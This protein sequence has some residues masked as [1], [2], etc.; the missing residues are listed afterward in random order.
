MDV[1][2]LSD[3]DLQ[4]LAKGDYKRI[5]D[6]GLRNIAGLPEPKPERTY[7][8][9]LLKDPAASLLSGLGSLTQFPGQL[10]G[11]VTGD[12]DTASVRAGKRLQ[13]TAEE[14]K[15][16]GLKGMEA[17]RAR[18]VQEAAER[19]GQ[20]GAFGTALGETL[21]SPSLLSGFLLEQAPQLLVPYGGAKIAQGASLA[22]SAAAGL[23]ALAAAE[24][25]GRTGVQAALGTAAVQQG[26][27]VGAGAYERIY[28]ELAKTMSP[29]EAAAETIN[30]ARAAGASGAII[31]LL[32]QKLPG[33]RALEEAFAGVP[34][35]A[36][37]A[38]RRRGAET[39]SDV[40]TPASRLGLVARGAAGEGASEVAE[41]VGGRFTQN[42][43][44]R[45]VKPEQALTE[46]LGETAAMALIGGAGMG[47][48]SGLLRRRETAEQPPAQPPAPEAPPPAAE[49]PQQ[50]PSGPDPEAVQRYVASLPEDQQRDLYEQLKRK[51][52][53]TPDQKVV[54][55]D[56]KEVT[57]P[58]IPAEL[59]TPQ[60][61]AAYQLLKAK[62][63]AEEKV[64]EAKP[65]PVD[66]TVTPPTDET[67]PTPS[68]QEEQE[69]TYIK[70]TPVSEN[71]EVRMW[72][73]KSGNFGVGV[74]DKDAGQFAPNIKFWPNREQA[75]EYFDDIVSKSA[76]PAEPSTS[77]TL[78]FKEYRPKEQ[79]D[80]D[81]KKWTI[82]TVSH[83]G[84]SL[85]AT[86]TP[87]FRREQ[88]I[89][90]PAKPSVSVEEKVKSLTDEQ[91]EALTDDALIFG[92]DEET[93]AAKAE[94]ARRRAERPTEE[95]PAGTTPPVTP[96]T[97]AATEDDLNKM[98]EELIEE[99][100]KAQ[101]GAAPAGAPAQAPA[102]APTPPAE[103]PVAGPAPKPEG[104]ATLPPSTTATQDIAAAAAKTAKAF[105]KAIDG[106][107]EL[108][109][110]GKKGRLGSGLSFDEETYAK[111]KPLFR[112]AIA[113]LAGA[114][115]DIRSA[116]RK[117]IQV[118][119]EKFGLD[120]AKRMQP[121]VVRFIQDEVQG[122]A[123]PVS[124]RKKLAEAFDGDFQNGVKFS[125]INAA[126]SRASE[127]LGRPV[128]P[129]TPDA[130]LVDE[131]VELAGVMYARRVVRQDRPINEIYQELIT[132]Q[133]DAMPRLAVR[134]TTSIVNQA[135]STPLPIA[136]VASQLA[137][138]N[139][140]TT[141]LEPTAGN[142][143]LLMAADP[144]KAIVNEI[145]AGR[146]N[147]LE[148]QGFAAT[149]ENA[150]TMQ[151]D[152]K[153]VDVVIANPPF[154]QTG[155]EYN[156]AGLKTGQIDHAIAL[157]ALQ[158]MKDDGRAVLIVGGPDRVDEDS[159]RKAYRAL[160]KRQFYHNLYN[161]Y[162]VKDHFTIGGDLYAKQGTTFPIDVI[163]IEGRG[164]GTRRQ[165]PAAALP[166]MIT[167]WDQLQGVL[168]G[169]NVD[170]G[171][172]R[173]DEAAT[174]GGTGGGGT[175]ARPGPVPPTT[176]EQGAEP[177][178]S[179]GSERVEPSGGTAEPRGVSGRPTGPGGGERPTGEDESRG[180]KRPR[181]VPGAGETTEEV[182]EEQPGSGGGV[183]RDD[184]TPMDRAAGTGKTRATV[185]EEQAEKLQVPY[186]NVSRSFPVNTLVATNHLT[187]IS[188]A[189]A[190]L[191]Q[192]VGNIDDYV[193]NKLQYITEDS[194][195][196]EKAI[197]SFIDNKIE[198]ADQRQL[199][200]YANNSE[201]VQHPRLYP[202][203]VVKHEN[204]SGVVI[205]RERQG[206]RI[207]EGAVAVLIDGKRIEIFPSKTS[208]IIQHVGPVAPRIQK[209]T[210][211]VE[212]YV[213]NSAA[214]YE[215]QKIFSAEQV[216]ALALAI[217]N[218]EAGRGFIIGDQT[219]IG[220]GRV[221]AA[222]IRY[223]MLNG[224][225]PV[226]LT[227]M[228]DLYGDMMRDLTDIGMPNVRPLM[229][230]NG[231]EVPLNAAA[232]RWFGEKQDIQIQ[233]EEIQQQIGRAHV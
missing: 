102:G 14:L 29:D 63:E 223:A 19:S 190:R 219:G 169:S 10:Y 53:G 160:S 117:I 201:L 167:T 144:N 145:E 139:D 28:E 103:V 155:G 23:P 129:G 97:G 46:G 16:A 113:N 191:E 137:G 226:F 122:Q 98:F 62:F 210:E 83:T 143:A 54:G 87:P 142:G 45:D 82:E 136:Y 153:S 217:Y 186:I 224:K 227:Q 126:R 120:I 73:A 72:Q 130:K 182:T 57:I 195:D 134:D 43:A 95:T 220:K 205:G 200:E 176:G 204:K 78:P 59:F 196:R 100:Q 91:L 218:I 135:Y 189:F 35:G 208:Q 198:I 8:E 32:A 56:G 116:M 125:N 215:L 123:G 165:Q 22:R 170:M 9:A 96:P 109:G 156:V 187:P 26:A 84:K 55:P 211:S 231:A 48:I 173:G 154:G 13:E 81:G 158:A 149:Q 180:A 80:F 213:F 128:E 216:E 159:R 178:E 212:Q 18:K 225:K 11:L 40:T 106:L 146:V 151:F 101:P 77:F 112:E 17:E 184:T 12:M 148:A 89:I 50:P 24:K 7:A 127:I 15:S 140:N 202:G 232:L 75:Q 5:S 228:P 163:V 69:R 209:I 39:V 188:E 150:A 171:P 174:G 30:R 64:E 88:F 27:D 38:I 229:T 90:A 60:E 119:A 61:Q 177:S 108:F 161:N 3:S 141:V 21:K 1:T 172:F 157:N 33:A 168:D 147:A 49:P 192:A 230:N 99:E 132:F 185:T 79:F 222:M 85:V 233:I 121:Y 47:G 65:P 110:A 2:R 131:A 66:E 58:G 162:N 194:G 124:D 34:A 133:N 207:P 115:A 107:G 68:G 41:E 37:R 197:K 70:Q 6:A 67:T 114:A 164:T 181:G 25:A 51:S 193:A 71:T 183:R 93:E 175:G 94:L 199:D 138:I 36:S 20:L 206:M 221:V 111:A 166:R 105:D 179:S 31:S 44:V 203:Q 86:T 118:I 76:P 214:E 92:P 4:A 104:V 74:Y 42:V 152:P 52:K